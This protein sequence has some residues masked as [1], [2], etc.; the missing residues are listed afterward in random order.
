[1]PSS[2]SAGPAMDAPQRASSA[3]PDKRKATTDTTQPAPKKSKAGGVYAAWRKQGMS[4]SAIITLAAEVQ[5][6]AAQ[7]SEKS[8]LRHH[9]LQTVRALIDA[10]D[11]L[12]EVSFAGDDQ[13][14]NVPTHSAAPVDTSTSDS[15]DSSSTDS[16]SSSTSSSSN[17]DPDHL[18]Q[19]AIQNGDYSM[20]MAAHIIEKISLPQRRVGVRCLAMGKSHTQGRPQSAANR[21]YP[22]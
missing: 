7:L 22:H 11:C 16:S 15:N 1:M 6:L 20:Q 13:P 21:A 12:H 2:G 18:A 4:P 3:P 14:I 9:V 17:V 5:L 19:L 10:H 8:E